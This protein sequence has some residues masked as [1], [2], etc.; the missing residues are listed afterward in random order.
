MNIYFGVCPTKLRVLIVLQKYFSPHWLQQPSLSIPTLLGQHVPLEVFRDLR[1][2]NNKA[3][4]GKIPK[5]NQE[6]YNFSFSCHRLKVA[7][8]ATCDV[9]E[10]VFAAKKN[11]VGKKSG[12]ITSEPPAVVNTPSRSIMDCPNCNWQLICRCVNPL[13]FM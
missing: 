8:L 1:T 3:R 12:D 11:N 9:A 5:N 6:L 4:N 7:E 10:A 13:S 2:E